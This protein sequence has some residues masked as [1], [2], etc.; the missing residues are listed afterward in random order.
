MCDCRHV[1]PNTRGWK[2]CWRHRLQVKITGIIRPTEKRVPQWCGYQGKDAAAT[3]GT[4]TTTVL[5]MFRFLIK[6]KAFWLLYTLWLQTLLI[7]QLLFV[8]SRNEWNGVRI[9][10]HEW[11]IMHA[12]WGILYIFTCKCIWQ[13]RAVIISAITS[14][15]TGPSCSKLMFL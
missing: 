8:C 10:C 9:D 13:L 11:F 14:S 15:P 6:K 5:T 3:E 4:A 7:Y 12:V 2:G 1:R